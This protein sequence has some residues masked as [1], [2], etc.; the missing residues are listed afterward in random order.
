MFEIGISQLF[1]LILT[2]SM[3]SAGGLLLAGKIHERRCE[4]ELKRNTF[5][6]RVCGRSY[7]RSGA[8]GGELQKCPDCASSNLTGPDRRLG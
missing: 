1:S 4:R 3:V 2:A 7:L 6:C 8:G 5:N